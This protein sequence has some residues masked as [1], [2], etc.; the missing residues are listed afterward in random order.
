MTGD[1]GGTVA[2]LAQA[3]RAGRGALLM[4]LDGIPIERAA[5]VAGADLES[6]AGEYAGLLRQA[7][8]LATALDSGGLLAYSVRGTDR[9]VVFRLIAG[10][11]ALGVEAGPMGLPGQIRHAL[12]QATEQL[13]DL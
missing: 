4:D 12:A 6:V 10:D 9:Q 1:L 7:Q 3:V 8:A 13:R 2:R 5:R 11:L